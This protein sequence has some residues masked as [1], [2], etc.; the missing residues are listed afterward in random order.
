MLVDMGRFSRRQG[1]AAMILV[2]K[3]EGQ[4]GVAGLG[5][6]GLNLCGSFIKRRLVNT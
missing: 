2:E 1:E 4:V 3:E 6:L 5:N